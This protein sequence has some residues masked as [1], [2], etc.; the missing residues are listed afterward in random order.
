[1]PPFDYVENLLVERID[2]ICREVGADQPPT[3]FLTGQGNF[4]NE[5]AKVRPYKHRA[6]NK[7]FHYY[8]IKAYIQGQYDFRMVD[9]LEADDLLAIEQ[10]KCN[11]ESFHFRT[12]ICSRDKDLRQVPGL[13]YGW[14][15]GK[16]ASFGPLLVDSFGKIWLTDKKKI[17]GYG[18]LFFY[19][20]C[21]TGDTVDTV[22]GL[23]KYGPVKAFKI[24]ENTQT[25]EQAFKAVLEAYR[26]FYGDVAEEHLL[27]QGR[28]LWMTRELNED[29]SPKLWEFPVDKE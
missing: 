4:R 17:K 2:R 8:N 10:T 23:P 29:G 20:Q 14:E 11:E 12:I 22:L 26:G 19:S 15:L 13:H 16:Q 18:E 5:I 28:L 9:G 21:L 6:G 27:E 25:S 24:L 7:P 1:M 3:L